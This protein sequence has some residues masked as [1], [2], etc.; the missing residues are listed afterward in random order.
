MTRNLSIL[1]LLLLILLLLANI[2]CA[3]SNIKRYNEKKSNAF[4]NQND[5]FIYSYSKPRSLTN[6]DSC[7]LNIECKG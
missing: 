2:L 4:D 3:S 5:A 7:H 6:S 1:P